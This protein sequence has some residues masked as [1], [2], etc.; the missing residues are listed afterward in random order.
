MTFV[1]LR[2]V[3]LELILVANGRLYR[4]ILFRRRTPPFA[5]MRA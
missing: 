3:R 5:E 4:R 1:A 2:F